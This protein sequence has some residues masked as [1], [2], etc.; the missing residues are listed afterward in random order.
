MNRIISFTILCVLSVS[1]YGQYQWGEYQS[2]YTNP[3]SVQI[4]LELNKRYEA[5]KA[6]HIE[7]IS[8]YNFLLNY[9]LTDNEKTLLDKC[10]TLLDA[11]T[12]RGDYENL[13]TYINSLKESLLTIYTKYVL[14]V[15]SRTCN[16]Y[17]TDVRT[18]GT[19]VSGY[20]FENVSFDN[21]HFY[22]VGDEFYAIV[23][24]TSLQLNMKL[25][26]GKKYVFGPLT[27]S[28]VQ[29]YKLAP[30]GETESERFARLVKVQRCDC[31]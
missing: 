31:E 13:G 10:L 26:R 16:E 25:A 17:I 2:T 18:I 7:N 11:I 1:A 29:A 30:V 24:Y 20:K 28:T 15:A 8:M 6:I 3:N 5:N 27:E 9:E 4:S 19:W 22:K 21:M 12:G 14:K 23:H